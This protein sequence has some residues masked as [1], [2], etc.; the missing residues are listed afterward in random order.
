MP[1]HDIVMGLCVSLALA[2]SLFKDR[3]GQMDGQ[4]LIYNKRFKAESLTPYR[5]NENQTKLV[6]PV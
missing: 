5:P 1:T 4:Y 6:S 2:H 3:D